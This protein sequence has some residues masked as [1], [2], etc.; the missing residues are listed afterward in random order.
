[1]WN[2]FPFL[3]NK[4]LYA[5]NRFFVYFCHRH[6]EAVA[7][8]FC[9][10]REPNLQKIRVKNRSKISAESTG[11]TFVFGLFN[12]GLFFLFKNCCW[13]RKFEDQ[14]CYCCP[15]ILK[16]LQHFYP[17]F[18]V[19]YLIFM[20]GCQSEDSLPNL[21]QS[22]WILLLQKKMWSIGSR[23]CRWLFSFAQPAKRKSLGRSKPTTHCVECFY[24]IQV[25]Q[26]CLL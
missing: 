22:H 7:N 25:L 2:I 3:T 12:Q 24:Y 8:N 21:T 20:L 9:R 11:F 1:M 19:Q 15:W 16:I 26:Y 23:L 6:M 14:V 5:K 13:A 18:K 17:W 4:L 10:F